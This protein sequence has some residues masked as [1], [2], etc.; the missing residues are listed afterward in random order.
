[1]NLLKLMV[2]SRGIAYDW[3]AH[4]GSYNIEE[5]VKILMKIFLKGFQA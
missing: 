1:M 3:C 4:S 2:F 5:E